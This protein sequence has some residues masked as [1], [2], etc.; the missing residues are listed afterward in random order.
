MSLGA[1]LS[2]GPSSCTLGGGVE[3]AECLG[4]GVSALP[5]PGLVLVVELSGR[6]RCGTERGQVS[7]A[8]VGRL[9]WAP[10]PFLL[11]A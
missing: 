1:R 7:V 5:H 6:E 9:A 3:G 11:A 2:P 10:Y 4:K 8:L